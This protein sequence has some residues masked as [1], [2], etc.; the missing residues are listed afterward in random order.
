MRHPHVSHTCGL[1]GP[2]GNVLAA[3]REAA[4]WLG[5]HWTH[6]TQG[7]Q[8]AGRR[9]RPAR[10]APTTKTTLVG[11]GAG[12]VVPARADRCLLQAGPVA[13]C[14]AQAGAAPL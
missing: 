14:Q 11:D 2:T 7:Q 6:P 12:W 10:E 4:S 13:G 8:S 3:L 5:S 1:A 9:G